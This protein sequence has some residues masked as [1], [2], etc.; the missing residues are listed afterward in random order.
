MIARATLRSV[1]R[2]CSI[3]SISQ[4][5]LW[6]FFWRK[7]GFG[8]GVFVAEQPLIVARDR[9]L[10]RVLIGQTDDVAA[11]VIRLDD[12][13]GED[14]GGAVGSIARSGSG[15]EAAKLLEGFLDSLDGDAGLLLNGGQAVLLEIVEV[16]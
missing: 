11:I 7:G 5:A 9:E 16:V 1:L 14:V 2:R 8:V 4:R 15:V 3:D 6:S 10:G 13:V 12:E